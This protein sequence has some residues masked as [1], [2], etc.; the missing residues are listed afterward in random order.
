MVAHFTLQLD[1]I[2]RHASADEGLARALPYTVKRKGQQDSARKEALLKYQ[3]LDH[4]TISFLRDNH[5]GWSHS[6]AS[7]WGPGTP[8]IVDPQAQIVNYYLQNERDSW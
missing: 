8:G 7:F 1:N 6:P 3:Q 4:E 5:I 2:F